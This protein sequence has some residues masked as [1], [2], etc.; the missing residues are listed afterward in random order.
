MEPREKNRVEPGEAVT[1]EHRG[2]AFQTFC[3]SS[4]CHTKNWEHFQVRLGNRLN[5]SGSAND[6]RLEYLAMTVST[7]CEFPR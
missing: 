3:D 4:A 7:L 5:N 1:D 2:S 6:H